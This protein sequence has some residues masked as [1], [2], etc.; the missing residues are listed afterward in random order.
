MT[1]RSS[2]EDFDLLEK[3]GS[4]SF[5]TVFKVRRR[6]DDIV[7]V[8]KTVRI[9]ELSMHE[10][11]EAINEVKLLSSLDSPFV[12][13]YYDSFIDSDSHQDGEPG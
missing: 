3:L 4:G 12:V 13:R 6:I 7:Y 1:V 10:Q 11:E 9:A 5:G 8:I 2:I